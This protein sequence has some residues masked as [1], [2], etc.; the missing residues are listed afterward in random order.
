VMM[1][2]AGLSERW[3]TLPLCCKKELSAT[4][5]YIQLSPYYK[6]GV[7]GFSVNLST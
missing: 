7:T 2:T 6:I 3:V 1:G 5:S 4:V